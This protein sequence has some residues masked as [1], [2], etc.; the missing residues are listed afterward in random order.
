MLGAKVRSVRW[1]AETRRW[2]CQL[3]RAGR[4][5][6]LT[7]DI[8]VCAVGLFGSP[9]RPEIAGLSNFGGTLM[10]TERA[11]VSALSCD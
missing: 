3:D 5:A 8:V 6:T 9:K 10:H 2:D 7:A 11:A 1:D 4:A